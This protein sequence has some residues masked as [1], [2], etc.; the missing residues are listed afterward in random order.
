MKSEKAL[1][2]ENKQPSVVD[3]DNEV[4]DGKTVIVVDTVNFGGPV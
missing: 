3:D 2:L 4:G 1:L